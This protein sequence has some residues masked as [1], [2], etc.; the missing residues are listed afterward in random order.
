[1]KKLLILG[2]LDEFVP[3][4]EM[5]KKRDIYTVVIDG[6]PGAP[7][8]VISDASYDMDVRNAD[9][10][11]II[12]KK[13]GI[14]AITT[15][16]S[17][18][19]FECA[20]NIAEK[21]GIPYHIKPDKLPYYRDK[22]V[23]NQALLKL[24]IPSPKSARLEKDFDAEALS[25]MTFPMVIKPL[26]KYGSR[27]II[28]VNSI[29]EIRRN[30]DE[31]C[32]TS[33]VKAV[34]AEEYND[35]H[36]FNI[37]CWVRHGVVNVLGICDREKT[38]FY[39]DRIPFSTRNIYPS[40]LIE[41]VMA[42]AKE[43]LTKYIGLTGQTEGPLCMQFYYDENRGFEVG[44][45]AARFLGYEHEL[46]YFAHNISIEALLIAGAL[47]DDEVDSLL[48]KCDPYG[49]RTAAVLYFHA[50]DGIIADQ[51]PAE[52]L[53]RRDDIAL[54][55]LF[56]KCGEPIG[57]PMTKPYFARY[58]IVSAERGEAD[59][60]SRQIIDQ[61]SAK[62]AEGNELVFKNQLGKY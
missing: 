61:V 44:E 33:D 23:T 16:Y 6:N 48:A 22:S 58:D 8:K 42:P 56:Y 26:D 5:A 38:F 24:G 62:D 27:G 21:A 10:I 28:I 36:E 30:F 19:L 1:M 15:A 50:R 14:E 7:A 4:V 11:A 20:A 18:L 57:D 54:S 29:E 17:D 13:E 40:R 52:D 32:R 25:E 9:E 41:K 45:I 31:S 12:C 3:L 49:K 35:G 43:A 47:F 55:Q 37:Q 53:C 60:L 46:L 51:A 34:L 59:L 39:P 2:G